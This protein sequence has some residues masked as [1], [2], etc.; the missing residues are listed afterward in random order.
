MNRKEVRGG[1]CGSWALLKMNGAV[2]IAS[3]KTLQ[4]SK[5]YWVREGVDE[6]KVLLDEIS[7][8]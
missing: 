1:S 7:E 2:L 5:R 4:W 3:P 6:N 8:I